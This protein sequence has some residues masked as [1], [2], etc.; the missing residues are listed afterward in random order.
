VA[1]GEFVSLIDPSG[2]GKSTLLRLVADI[3]Q[4]SRG[5]IAVAG[6]SPT[7]ARLARRYAFVFQEPV[8]LPWRSV[9]DNIGLPLELA[10]MPAGERSAQVT[11]LLH[12]VQL[13]GFGPRLPRELSGGMRMR[14]SLARALTH[15]P[16]LLLMDEPFGALDEIA[17]AQMNREL[18]QVWQ[19]TGAAVLFVTHSIDEAVLLSDRVVVMSPRPGRIA[20]IIDIDLARPRDPDR[21]EDDPA[22]D[23]ARRQVRQA[24]RQV[25]LAHV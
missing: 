13:D 10:G 4:P 3:L 6:L 8:L 14:A 18:M 12:T 15:Q 5:H 21:L 20:E 1:A 2:C 22:F 17:R 25:A 7:A 9:A 16:P 23:A 11:R 24:L 19:N